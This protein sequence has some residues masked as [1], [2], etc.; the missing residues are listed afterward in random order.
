MNKII[1]WFHVR[2]AYNGLAAALGVRRRWLGLEPSTLFKA[3]V[4]KALHEVARG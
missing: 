2:R 3:R 4:Y 1:T